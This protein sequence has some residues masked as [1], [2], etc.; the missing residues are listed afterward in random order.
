MQIHE[1]SQLSSTKK[2]WKA[3]KNWWE[4]KWENPEIVIKWERVWIWNDDDTCYDCKPSY[5]GAKL[6]TSLRTHSHNLSF[7]TFFSRK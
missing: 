6:P 3:K 5:W 4:I 7:G 1:V 2:I